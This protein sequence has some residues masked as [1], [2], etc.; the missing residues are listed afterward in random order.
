MKIS[1][2]GLAALLSCLTL[3]LTNF[4]IQAEDMDKSNLKYSNGGI[5]QEESDEMK[6]KAGDFNLRLY[7]SEGKQ[8]HFITDTKIVITDKNGIDVL[9]LASGGPMLFVDVKNGIYI[10]K[11]DYLG[12]IITRKVVVANHRGVNVYLTWKG[13]LSEIESDKSDVVIE[14]NTAQ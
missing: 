7:M 4:P 10:I 11:A 13:D 14:G 12:S 2:S 8:G 3:V 5:G 6:A 9:N 1:K